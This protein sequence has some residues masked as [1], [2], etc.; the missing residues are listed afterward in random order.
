MFA[1]F[2]ATFHVAGIT[3]AERHTTKFANS[4][5]KVERL[6]IAWLFDGYSAARLEL[7]QDI[8]V[9]DHRLVAQ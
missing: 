2:C 6:I 1:L 7:R 3:M 8:L 4:R 5:F 9:V